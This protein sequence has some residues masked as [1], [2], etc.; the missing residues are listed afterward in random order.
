[1]TLGRCGAAEEA[2]CLVDRIAFDAV[3]SD[4]AM[5]GASG[6]DLVGACGRAVGDQVARRGS[7][8][9]RAGVRVTV[10]GEPRP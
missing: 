8:E 6:Y 3:V 1:M 9:L 5:P 2:L 4:I 7:E 10:R